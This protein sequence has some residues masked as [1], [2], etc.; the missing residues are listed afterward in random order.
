MVKYLK[1]PRIIISILLSI[2][3][4]GTVVFGVNPWVNKII[5][6]AR[7]ENNPLPIL[8]ISIFFAGI[9]LRIPYWR[10][11]NQMQNLAKYMVTS[12]GE[13]EFDEEETGLYLSGYLNGLI[14]F[15]GEFAFMRLY[16]FTMYNLHYTYIDDYGEEQETVPSIFIRIG[17]T[18]VTILMIPL[19]FLFYIL[20]GYTM[21]VLVRT[22]VGF[23]TDS[24]LTLIVGLIIIY[25]LQQIVK[26]IY[27]LTIFSGYKDYLALVKPTPMILLLIIPPLLSI[28]GFVAVIVSYTTSINISVLPIINLI[29]ILMPLIQS[30]MISIY[31]RLI[32]N[33]VIGMIELIN[34]GMY[35]E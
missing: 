30:I 16:P 34:M 3:V 11:F 17:K 10:A 35:D 6:N 33:D 4:V 15:F 20:L 14:P 21:F 23:L 29:I 18:L 7:A 12:G 9:A 2:I 31:A 26:T 24:N 1:N 19:H 28:I 13:E 22:N 5:S 8:G 32:S 27:F 25:W